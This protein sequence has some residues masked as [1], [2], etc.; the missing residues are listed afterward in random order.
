MKQK[1]NNKFD[2]N[3]FNNVENKKKF[4]FNLGPKNNCKIILDKKT[5]NQIEEAFKTE[6]IKLGYL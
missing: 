5:S 4:S 3:A 2:E 1:K 6:L